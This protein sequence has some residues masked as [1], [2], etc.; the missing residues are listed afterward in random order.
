MSSV[1]AMRFSR[2]PGWELVQEGIADLTMG[3]LTPAACLVGLAARRLER[4]GVLSAALLSGMPPE[5]EITL[6]RLWGQHP[7]DAYAKYSSFLRRLRR[8]EQ[9]L[10][11]ELFRDPAHAAGG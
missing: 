10:D 4:V 2:L 6:Y 11:R 3:K 9:A 5:P 1:A 8:L 7:G